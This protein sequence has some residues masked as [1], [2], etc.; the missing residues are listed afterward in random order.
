V[1]LVWPAGIAAIACVAMLTIRRAPDSR[2]VSASSAA[3]R[4]RFLPLRF[5]GGAASEGPSSLSPA[6]LVRAGAI[7][8]GGALLIYGVM[9]L[10]GVLVVHN[11]LTIDR[12]IY[13]WTIT[14]RLHLWVRLMDRLT[15]IG[16]TW[17]TW[18]AAGAAAVCLVAT[19]RR[20]RWLPPLAL[21]SLVLLDHFLTLALRHTIHRL[22]PPGSPLGTFPS[23]GCERVIVF[24]G[25]IAYMLW[26]EHSGRRRDAIWAAAAVAALAFNEGYSRAYLTL[27]WF[28]DILSG[29]LY[30]ALLLAVFIIAVRV[31]AGPA[32]PRASRAGTAGPGSTERLGNPVDY[33]PA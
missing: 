22:G 9:A 12:P 24:Y 27:H 8:A 23:G 11:G 17:T 20:S 26:R 4:D 18:G 28:T 25:L 2:A 1:I 5:L 16:D 29:W 10:L 32:T 6:T 30:G 21:G 3:R 19:W 7:L 31:L 15:K 14:H 33:V 13:N